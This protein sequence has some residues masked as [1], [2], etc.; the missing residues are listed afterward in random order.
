[1]SQFASKWNNNRGPGISD[2]VRDVI[3]TD[4]PLKPRLDNAIKQINIQIT[5][6]DQTN[7][8]LKD[9]DSIIFRNVVTAMKSHDMPH[10][11]IYANELTELR[12]MTKMV[13]QSKLALEHC[14]KTHSWSNR[15]IPFNQMIQEALDKNKK[16]II[17]GGVRKE[18][19]VKFI[20]NNGRVDSRKI[21]DLLNWGKQIG[22]KRYRNYLRTID[23]IYTTVINKKEYY[24][25]SP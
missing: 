18:E 15:I 1:M 23:G 2:K 6:L 19:I 13:N 3:R 14:T 20:K 16:D 9:K 11:T 5:K 12:K 25:Y 21:R 24:V 7:N 8:R 10:A 22:F 4:S 17:K